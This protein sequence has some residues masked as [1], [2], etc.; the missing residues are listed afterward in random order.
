MP[1]VLLMFDWQAWGVLPGYHDIGGVWRPT[2]DATGLSLAAAMG[3][4][5]DAP[6]PEPGAPMRFVRPAD[7]SASA[8]MGMRPAD[9]SASGPVPSRLAVAQGARLV[10]EDGT[11]L[12]C[13]D[14]R[15]PAELPLGYHHV[16]SD[17]GR[18]LLVVTPGSCPLP[19]A[20]KSWGWALQLYSLLSR[21][22]W[23]V[24]DLTDLASFGQMARRLGADYC[25]VN[26]L[27]AAAPSGPMQPSPYS[28]SSR[29]WRNPLYLRV[30]LVPGAAAGPAASAVRAAARAGL[31]LNRGPR[32]D[33]DEVWAI[34]RAALEAIWSSWPAGASAEERAAWAAFR[35]AHGASLQR[36]A[37]FAALSEGFGSDARLWPAPYRDCSSPAVAAYEEA[38]PAEVGFHAWLQW[39]IDVQLATAGRSIGL[40]QDLAIGVDG[41]GADVWTSPGCYPHG[42]SVGAPPDAFN[43]DGQDWGLLPFDPWGLRRACYAPFIQT[44]RSCLRSAAALRFDHVMGLF[45]LF[46]LTAG[47]AAAGGTYVGYPAADLLDLLALEA[48]RAGSFVVGEDLG[49][50]EDAVRHELAGRRVLGYRVFWF[51]GDPPSTYPPQSLAALTTHDLPTVTGLW[52][53]ADEVAQESIGLS[54]D[55][56]GNVWIR[57]RIGAWTG[58]PP[59]A[60]AAAVVDALHELLAGAGSAVALASLE[61]GL[62][63]AER[64]NMPGTVGAWPNWR[65]V[66]PVPLEAIEGQPGVRAIA[67]RMAARA[68]PPEPAS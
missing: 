58:L 56:K 8:P 46:W 35:D 54:P 14:G 37:T 12:A 19:G 38:H 7:L 3:G 23:G 55:R 59:D 68:R 48:T 20:P 33:R 57:E 44:L 39:L 51:E 26:P 18:E 64:P 21:S 4:G 32:I 36:F 34:K 15:L 42:V 2:S 27:H 45:R 61:D 41:G 60:P 24:G 47:G 17:E 25:L 40:M 49:T 66:L 31:A 9:A 16:E 67:A 52:T 11:D 30:E 62:A 29:I 28:P 5:P 65:Q 10:L 63:V 53:G 50:V 1:A 22:S 6:S 13:A 43:P